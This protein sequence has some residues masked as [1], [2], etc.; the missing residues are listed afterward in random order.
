MTPKGDSGPQTPATTPAPKTGWVSTDK[1]PR[2][3]SSP[4]K[5][6]YLKTAFDWTAADAYLFDID[7]T[8]LNSRDAVHYFAFHNA[9][10]AVFGKDSNTEGIPIHG[11]TDIGILRAITAKL[12]IS[13]A[14]FEAGLPRVRELMCADAEQNMQQFRPELCESIAEVLD[15]L[16]DRGKLMGI[17]SGNLERIGW[18]KLSVA[19]LREYFSFGTFAGDRERRADIFRYGLGEATT[20][21]GSSATVYVV[22]DTPA[23]ILAA[24]ECMA[25]IIAIA[26]G[27]YS[28]EELIAHDPDLC[29]SSGADL[30]SLTGDSQ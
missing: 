19:G 21:L 14:E 8:L 25:P 3:A 28:F 23:D 12:G 10:R 4:G 26:S 15:Y 13:S 29:A 5:N 22:G 16:R 6:L 2:S 9:L 18:L 11:N 24:R 30:L 20:R 17:A 27:I 1:K 7:G